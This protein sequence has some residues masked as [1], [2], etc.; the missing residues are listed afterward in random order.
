MNSIT[1]ALHTGEHCIET[2]AKNELRRLTNILL[3]SGTECKDT[4]LEKKIELLLSFLNNSDF[5][6]LRASDER[7][8]GITPAECIVA[9]NGQGSVDVVIK[10]L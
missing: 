7:L 9:W 1:V 10:K 3:E 5:N 8:A 6:M 4:A 2:S